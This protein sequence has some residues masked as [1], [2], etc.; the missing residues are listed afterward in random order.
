MQDASGFAHIE[1]LMGVRMDKQCFGAMALYSINAATRAGRRARSRIF[2]GSIVAA[3]LLLLSGQV[4]AQAAPPGPGLSPDLPYANDVERAAAA[5]NQ[6]A[7]LTLNPICNPGG[8]FDNDPAPVWNP[9]I[10]GGCT[11]EAFAVFRTTRELAHTANELQAT[12]PTVASLGL[13]QEGLGLALRWTAAEEFAANASMATGF[14]NDQLSNI[15]ARMSAL[16][17]GARGFSVAAIPVNVEGDTRVASL[18]GQRRGAGASA[19]DGGESYSPWGGFIN[20]AF[21]WG[22][23]DPTDLENAFDFDGT[24]ITAGID[25]RFD[26]NFILGGMVGYTEQTL[27]FDASASAISVV[28]GGIEATGLSYIAFG[29]FQGE[30]LSFSAS[31]GYQDLEYDAV[32]HIKYPSFNPNL[33]GVNATT[34]SSPDSSVVMGTMN[35]AYALQYK[36]LT[37]EPYVNIEYLD[38]TIDQ[39][40]EERSSNS[41]SSLN[42]RSFSLIIDKQ[43]IKSV[44]SALGVKFQLTLTPAFAVIIPYLGYAAHSESEDSAR[45]ISAHFVGLEALDPDGFNVP[46]DA[47]DSSYSNAY[48]GISMVLRGGRQRTQGGAIHGGLQGYIQYSRIDGLEFYDDEVI[49]GGFRYEF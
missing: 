8:I 30:K 1:W 31:L 22:T 38:V 7:Y 40:S 47:R 10:G 29:L 26:N 12:G 36:R 11:E 21:G 33:S 16:R 6:A 32:R 48:A 34:T 3:S 4:L 25:Y 14:A 42:S 9:L 23:K 44:D 46:T 39:F 24:E 2:S 17:F 43:S 49:S 19:D 35:L 18:G 13:D 20:G 41:L 37:F 45:S 28:D 27:D 5:A 15:A